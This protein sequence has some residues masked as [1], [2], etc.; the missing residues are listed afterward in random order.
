[1]AFYD[2]MVE[3]YQGKD[4]ARG[5]LAGDMVRS[6]DFPRC[7]SRDQI[8]NYLHSKFACKECV[9]T[10]KRAWVAYEKEVGREGVIR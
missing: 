3:K 10:F 7:G 9:A 1:M 8:M 2:W 6:G 4:S 5:D